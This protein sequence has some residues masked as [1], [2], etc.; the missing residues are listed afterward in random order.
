M[1]Y[2]LFFSSL[3]V[4]SL[5]LTQT[6][7]AGGRGGKDDDMDKSDKD[8]KLALKKNTDEDE[9]LISTQIGL[10]KSYG[11]PPKA[12]EPTAPDDINLSETVL[13]HGEEEDWIALEKKDD[14]T[15]END[16]DTLHLKEDTPFQFEEDIQEI[17]VAL[18]PPVVLTKRSDASPKVKRRRMIRVT[19]A[20]D[21][22]TGPRPYPHLPLHPARRTYTPYSKRAANDLS[23]EQPVLTCILPEASAPALP[24][25]ETFITGKYAPLAHMPGVTSLL[26]QV[27][28]E[29]LPAPS[30]SD[31]DL[32]PGALNVLF[33]DA[34]LPVNTSAAIDS[35]E[36]LFEAMSQA[37]SN[38]FGDDETSQEDESDGAQTSDSDDGT[39]LI[40]RRPDSPYPQERADD[41]EAETSSEV[42][43][44][45]SE[46]GE[47]SSDVS[48][49]DEDESE[50]DSAESIT[51]KSESDTD[52]SP[53]DD[54][55]IHPT[56][57]T[58]VRAP[59]QAMPLQTQLQRATQYIVH[60]F[61]KTP[62]LE[63]M[64][65]FEAFSRLRRSE[66]FKT[67]TH[68]S[69]GLKITN[70]STNFNIDERK[71][72]FFT[73]A[74]EA[75]TPPSRN[76][77]SPFGD[78]IS[79]RPHYGKTTLPKIT[80]AMPVKKVPTAK[81]AKADFSKRVD[82]FKEI[83]WPQTG[84][85]R[86]LPFANREKVPLFADC[87]Y[88]VH[89]GNTRKTLS[90]KE[91]H[92]LGRKTCRKLHLEAV[93]EGVTPLWTGRTPVSHTST[94][95]F[96]LQHPVLKHFFNEA[97]ENRHHTRR[98]AVI[99]PDAFLSLL[100]SARVAYDTTTPKGFA[101]ARK[102]HAAVHFLSYVKSHA[103]HD[104]DVA[105]VKHKKTVVYKAS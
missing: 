39:P 66:I 82:D 78:G 53:W 25:I 17:E 90:G 101:L 57:D 100:P 94:H 92:T 5:S 27:P 19:S 37:T 65:S 50:D 49:W 93:Y 80:I 67:I 9:G 21:S 3:M 2:K 98:V 70:A 23:L 14:H 86:D 64:P 85:L 13:A 35:A 95:A 41:S 51:V 46:S 33:G 45:D 71:N 58:R 15:P 12:D 40:K 103:G 69:G 7:W 29:T 18:T 73:G 75:Q 97:L 48:S 76:A 59:S 36:A 47:D 63:G 99:T 20:P 32:D 22:H 52:Q 102:N 28:Q 26:P 24:V 8:A 38:H 88:T 81:T 62:L 56:S 83:A 74:P 89:L 4:V 91:L 96:S 87:F 10:E 16:E 79:L 42:T 30:D 61:L 72:G 54:V 43:A 11:T 1:S 105:W 84:F 104:V 60:G 68:A 55:F 6:P 77:S 34:P 44:S 31:E